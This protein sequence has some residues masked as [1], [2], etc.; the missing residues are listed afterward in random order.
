MKKLIEFKMRVNRPDLIE[1]FDIN[2]HNPDMLYFLKEYKNTV[3]VPK[4]WEYKKK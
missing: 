3:E 1:D 4:N 2:S